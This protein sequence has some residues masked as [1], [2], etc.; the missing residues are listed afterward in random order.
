MAPFPNDRLTLEEGRLYD[1]AGYGCAFWTGR[2]VRTAGAQ[3]IPAGGAGRYRPQ[4]EGGAI[5]PDPRL[6]G[7]GPL[8]PPRFAGQ[9][10]RVVR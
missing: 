7:D 2:G 6:G 10:S 5:A 4:V 1:I 3:R 8:R 9:R